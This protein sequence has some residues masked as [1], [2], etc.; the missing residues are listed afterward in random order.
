MKKIITTLFLGVLVYGFSLS[1][2]MSDRAPIR[3]KSG[4]MPEIIPKDMNKSKPQLQS[5]SG[6]P[7]KLRNGATPTGLQGYYDYQSNGWS[8]Q[9]IVNGTENIIH[10]T[11]MLS[12]SKGDNDTNVLSTNRKVGYAVSN[13]GGVT[14]K[15]TKQIDPNRRG[16]PWLTLGNEGV[17]IIATHGTTPSDAVVRTF[18]YAG[19]GGTDFLAA[20]EFPAENAN[21]SLGST[22]GSAS[23]TIWPMVAISPTDKNKAL[24]FGSIGPATVAEREALNVSIV[25]IGA[26][27]TPVW[28]SISESETA[29]TSGGNYAVSTSK[30]G[31]IGVVWD[32]VDANANLENSGLYFSESSD[33]VK[34]SAPVKAFGFNIHN[35]TEEN[36]DE[37]TLNYDGIVDI[38]YVGEEANIVSSGSIN[39]LYSSRCIFQWTPSRGLKIIANTDLKSGLGISRFASNKNQ[40]NTG[41][42]CYP[43]V[44]VA[45]NNKNLMIA[46]QAW[47]PS[48]ETGSANVSSE[49]GF[50][51]SRLWAI[52]SKD[53]GKNWGNPILVQDFAGTGTDSASC[54]YPSLSPTCVNVNGTTTCSMVFQARR[55]PGAYAFV[56]NYDADGDGT[57]ETPVNRPTEFSECFQYFQKIS[58]PD[59]QAGSVEKEESSALAFSIRSFPNPVTNKVNIQYTLPNNGDVKI[60]LFNMIGEQIGSI[61]NNKA[62]AGTYVNEFD[63]T[64]FPSGTY[65]CVVSQNGKTSS[66]MIHVSK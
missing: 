53:G 27:T 38:A 11:Y 6:A 34:W 42:V 2:T 10:T 59:N 66:R 39:N 56:S 54:E 63:F 32:Y 57:A 50:L 45:D 18:L 49:E 25:E 41:F 40:P 37:D 23:G 62:F 8:P 12:T 46:F 51:Y 30:K 17:P 60:Q 61:N 48:D 47:A 58:I 43:S 44:S 4:P 31:K 33:G 7:L 21:G 36:G 20:N 19:I 65:R 15:S 3:V 52:A 1:Q 13:D 26:S 29:K 5:V 28:K 22:G 64:N 24:V 14:W 35:I 55:Y 16:F 9:Y